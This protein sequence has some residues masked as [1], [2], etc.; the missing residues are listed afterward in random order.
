MFLMTAIVISGSQQEDEA[1]K[2][3]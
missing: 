1:Q 3:S 2:H